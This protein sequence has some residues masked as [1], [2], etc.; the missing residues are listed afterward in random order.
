VLAVRGRPQAPERRRRHR[1]RHRRPDT[2]ADTDAD[3]DSDTDSDTDADTDAD[4]DSDTDTDTDTDTLPA[5]CA[6]PPSR[7]PW[8]GHPLDSVGVLAAEFTNDARLDLV[9]AEA[10]GATYPLATDLQV[11]RATVTAIA[12]TWSAGG[13]DYANF[14]LEDRHGA[15]YAFGVEVPIDLAVGDVVSVQ[16]DEVGVAPRRSSPAPAPAPALYLFGCA[17]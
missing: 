4:T 9:M 12:N 15:V 6:T 14:Y 5:R 7:A 8:V 13:Y 16:V 3:T 17:G 10:S 11:F 1:H 2:D